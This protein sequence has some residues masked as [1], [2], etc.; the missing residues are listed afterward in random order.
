[1]PP[2]RVRPFLVAA[3]L[4]TFVP[5][6]AGQSGLSGPDVEALSQALR[7][8]Q[9]AHL[10]RVG[11]WGLANAVGGA[12]LVLASDRG[13][14]PGRWAFGLQS[15]AW[16]VVNVGIATV[17]LMS[18]LGDVSA[19]W[20]QAFATENGYAD[21]LLLNL[22]LNVGYAAVGGTLLAVAG[23]G[24]ANPAAWRGHGAALVLQGAGLFVL[25]GV[26]YLGTR[27]RLG[28]LT[29]VASRVD[30]AVSGSGIVLV[31]PL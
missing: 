24:V 7:T 17:G 16:G 12:T 3:A 10:W 30:L 18:G 13:D 29:E 8:D 4:L 1:M 11:A 21:V 6:A 26:A 9:Q 5:V 27:D 14:Q 28:A 31:L 22:G 20:A 19:D 2:S 25:D 23:R 15:G